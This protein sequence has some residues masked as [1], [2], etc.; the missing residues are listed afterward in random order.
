MVKL[1]IRPLFLCDRIIFTCLLSSC[2]YDDI[3]LMQDFWIYST[4][5]LDLS[6]EFT[7]LLSF[8]GISLPSLQS[9]L[10]SKT[11]PH[12]PFPEHHNQTRIPLSSTKPVSKTHVSFSFP[13]YHSALSDKT[14]FIC[15]LHVFISGLFH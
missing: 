4:L 5:C 13:L 14:L 8:F 6:L 10:C 12:K 2:I 9:D 3:N 1:T 7:N 15:L 11:T